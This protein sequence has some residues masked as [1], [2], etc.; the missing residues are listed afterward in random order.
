MNR[1]AIMENVQNHSIK[2]KEYLDQDDYNAINKLQDICFEHDKTALKLE[3]DYKLASAEEMVRAIGNINEF[4]YFDEEILVGYIGICH[5][6]G[7]HLEVNGMVHPD[8]RRQ[9]IFK[10]LFQFVRDEWLRRGVGGMLLLSDRNSLPGQA[11]IKST[12]ASYKHSE[13]EMYLQNYVESHSSDLNFEDIIFK[14]ATN[15]DAKEVARQN[16]I[17]FG[18]EYDD[19]EMIKPEE[20][21]R[22]GMAI[23]LVENSDGIIGKVH[24]QLINGL[25]AIFGL[26]VLPEYRSKGYGRKIILKSVEMLKKMDAE[27]IMLQVEAGNSNALNL[28]KSCGFVETSTM[29]YFEV[30]L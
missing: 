8:Y 3:L 4:M 10:K 20:E 18:M 6:G 26:G 24:L 23:F 22:R 13:Y 30:I 17:Y 14:K 28:Y 1:G 29:D 2:L 21:E 25:G 11:F 7:P 15:K 12:T 27:E 9:G 16:A 5:F 19:T